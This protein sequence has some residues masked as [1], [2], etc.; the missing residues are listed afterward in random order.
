MTALGN[1]S[2]PD[3]TGKAVNHLPVL[4]YSVRPRPLLAVVGAS[5]CDG[6]KRGHVD[7]RFV[8]CGGSPCI[9]ASAFRPCVQGLSRYGNKCSSCQCAL[10]PGTD[11]LSS[12]SCPRHRSAVAE[13]QGGASAK[14]V[15]CLPY[16]HPVTVM[17]PAV[18]L[19]P[20]WLSRPVSVAV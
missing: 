8:Q 7:T 1:A 3:L 17:T 14:N 9:G 11:Q 15:D 18:F 4:R 20:R 6:A 5:A 2:W 16:R 13:P 19:L 12:C 10:V